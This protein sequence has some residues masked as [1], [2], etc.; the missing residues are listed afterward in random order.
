MSTAHWSF[1]SPTLPSFGKYLLTFFYL[2][3]TLFIH[4]SLAYVF[5][6]CA[7]LAAFE[8]F[9]E[10][11][12]I[13]AKDNIYFGWSDRFN[14]IASSN[15]NDSEFGSKKI[16]FIYN[17]FFLFYFFLFSPF[18]LF[19]SF[20]FPFFFFFPYS[21][22]VLHL[23]RGARSPSAPLGLGY[24]PVNIPFRP[25]HSPAYAYGYPLSLVNTECNVY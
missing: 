17:N 8:T 25:V 1:K 14:S 16:I 7:M 2:T 21:A 18:L 12:L 10:K 22:G 4:S 9:C 24:G 23:Q 19:F 3:Y 20:F 5:C 6:V 11:N 13:K 15:S